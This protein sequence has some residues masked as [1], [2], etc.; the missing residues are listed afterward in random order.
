MIIGDLSSSGRASALQAE[1]GGFESR[2]FHYCGFDPHRLH[3]LE[4]LGDVNVSRC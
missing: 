4:P 1:G 2:R 3:L